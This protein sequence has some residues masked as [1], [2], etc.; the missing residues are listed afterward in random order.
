[1]EKSLNGVPPENIINYDETSLT[2]D[3]GRW[4]MIFKRGAHYPES[5]LNGTKASTSL[6][7]A[8][9]ASGEV[10][11]VYVIYKSD[12]LWNIWVEGGPPKQDTTLQGLDG[13]FFVIVS[14]FSSESCHNC[15]LVYYRCP[16]IYW[17]TI[18]FKIGFKS[19][20]IGCIALLMHY[21]E[22]PL[23]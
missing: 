11:P 14:I 20:N 19:E 8:G 16:T 18:D 21:F 9:T 5:I 6:M 3:P 23:P 7:L 22:L 13:F 12:H 1:M 2:N 15:L 4:Q 17:Y 10:L